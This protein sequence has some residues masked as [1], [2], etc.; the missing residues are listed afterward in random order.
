MPENEYEVALFRSGGFHRETCPTCKT[1]YWTMG[2]H[3]TCGETPC[4]EYDFLGRSPM[5]RALPPRAMREEFLSFFES[6]DHTRVK[7]YPVV[8]RWRDDVFFTQASVYPFQPWVIDGVADPPANPL[9]IS[10]PCVRFNDIDNVGKTGQHFTL[11]EMLAHHAFNRKN[12]P[13]YWKDRTVEL[14]HAFFTERLGV[15][16]KLLRYKES[17]WAGGGNSGPCFEVILGGAE[18]ATLVFMQF[19]DANGNRIPMETQ[20]VDTGY[21]LERLT[22][23]SQGAPSAYEAVFGDM[24]TYMKRATGTMQIDGRLLMEYSKVAG[25]SNIESFA[26]IRAVRQQTADRLGISVDELMRQ[27]APLENIYAALDH[28]RALMFVLADGVVP[29]NSREGYFARLLVRRGMRALRSLDLDMKLTDLA[30]LFVQ[31]YMEDFPEVFANQRDIL[32]LMEVEQRRYAETL[33]KGRETVRRVEAD[34]KAG[35]AAGIGAD[36]L[37][38][39]YDSHG[40]TPEVVQEFAEMPVEVPDD[41][42]TRVA[43]RHETAAKEQRVHA[44]AGTPPPSRSRVH[45]DGKKQRFFARV[46]AVEGTGVVLDQTFFYPEG[47]GQEADHGTIR[48]YDVVDVQQVG[49]SVVHF[50][51]GVPSNLVVGKRVKCDID[52]PR[53]QRLRRHHTATHVTLG[54]ARKVLGN[55][56]WQTGA[57]KAEDAARLDITHYDSLT[58][59][60]VRRIEA[61]ANEIVLSDRKVATKFVPRE[62]AERKYGFRLYQ[63]GSVPGAKLRV[64][65]I[66][67]WDIEACGGTHCARTSEVGLVKV[68]RSTRIQDGV[69]RLEYV[70]GSAA[71]EYVQ[72]QAQAMD[73]VRGRLGVSVDRVPEAVAHLQEEAKDLRKRVELLERRSIESA[74]RGEPAEAGATRTIPLGDRSVDA[75]VH[76]IGDVR[77]WTAIVAPGTADDLKRIAGTI[78]SEP[79]NVVALAARNASAALLIGRSDGVRLDCLEV[80]RAASARVGGG[81]GGAPDFAQGGGPNLDGIDAALAEAVSRIRAALG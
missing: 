14:C 33:T 56:V 66:P 16:P 76:S 80:A 63:G 61:L 53:R 54:A 51:K 32:K 19:K 42:F 55:H 52:W 58:D 29:S 13:I 48:G 15:D 17:Q 68:L 37:V 62:L 36:A 43:R 64:V 67:E 4:Q 24:L 79:G 65:E 60:E 21:G 69:V 72:K 2:D 77:L 49:D 57:H 28:A 25:A 27:M 26:D 12:K 6:N 31:H 50:T 47:G 3:R 30:T 73:A 59:E 11:F 18:V 71:I 20:V 22:W 70:A 78:V 35:G 45:E 75:T 46:L 44:W 7:R 34:L 8:A 23:V 9:A 5:K 40:L 38:E 10:Q 81:A 1:P 74:M 39:L 41:F